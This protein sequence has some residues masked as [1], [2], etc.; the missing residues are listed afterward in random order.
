MK[1]AEAKLRM[2]ELA[3]ILHDASYRYYVLSQPTL[4]DAEYDRLFRELENLEAEF[5]ELRQPDSPCLRVGAIPAAQ[6]VSVPHAKPMLSL[7]NAMNEEELL[8]FDQQVRKFLE[9]AGEPASNLTYSVELKF[10]GVALSLRYQ[11]GVLTQALTRG[12]G[13][14]GEDITHNVRTIRSVPL[15]LRQAEDVPEVLEVRGEVVFSKQAFHLFNEERIQGGEEPFANPRNAASGSLRQLDS[16]ETARRKLS[17]YAYGVGAFEGQ[18]LPDTHSAT[19]QYLQSVGFQCSPFLK[20]AQTAA[21]LCALYREALQVREQL[22]FEVDGLV[23]KVESIAMQEKLGFRQRSPRWATA[24]KFAPVEEHTRLLDIIVQVG[25]TGAVTPVALLEPVRVGGVVVSRATLHNEDEIRRKDLRIGDLVVVRR[26]G[27]V[28]P[29]VAAAVVSART[30]QEREFLFPANCPHCN[31]LLQRPEGEA[32]SRCVNQSCPAR[33]EQRILHYASR[34]GMDIEGLGEKWVAILVARGL[35][36]DLA[37][38]YSLSRAQLLELPRMGEALADK[39]LL[40]IEKSK[41]R[42]LARFIFALGIRHVGERTAAT[43]ARASC[44]IH[45]FL[46]LTHAKLETIPD[47]GEETAAAVNEF[48]G[49]QQHVEEIQ[50]LLALGVKPAAAEAHATGPLTGLT[51]VLTGTLPTLSRQEAQALIEA[52]GG[53]VSGSVSKK[54]SFVVAGVEAGSKLD[55][56]QALSVPI[57]DEEGFRKVLARGPTP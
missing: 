12:D 17:F 23:V 29:A 37:G 27:D 25:R 26:Q 4:S 22:P 57:L 49:K 7:S 43:L 19:L 47:I 52:A 55:K 42:P 40:A 53:K 41:S 10:D 33:I 14:S 1:T 30:G 54:T 39:L 48:I 51:F 11:E 24:A 56:A 8:A 3:S 32:V 36:R 15:R 44:D 20:K 50:A 5:P 38:I 13:I 45:G 34:L 46:S 35:V 2:Q 28:I 21:E 16:K 6:F 31:S 18:G 9:D